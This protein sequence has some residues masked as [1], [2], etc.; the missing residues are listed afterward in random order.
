[1]KP[2]KL[3]DEEFY[4][5]KRHPIYSSILIKI[6]LFYSDDYENEGVK[7]YAN[8][9][10]QIALY[11]HITKYDG[12]PKE[13]SHLNLIVETEI[14]RI[15]DIYQALSSKRCYKD[16]FWKDS[17]LEIIEK[18]RE[19]FKDSNVL[20][21]F[22]RHRQELDDIMEER[23][24]IPEQFIS[25]WNESIDNGHKKIEAKIKEIFE[26]EED[27]VL[28]KFEEL[29]DI[30]ESHFRE[31]ESL[32]LQYEYPWLEA[33]TNFHEDMLQRLKNVLFYDIKDLNKE[34]LKKFII[35]WFKRA[36]H[37]HSKTLD[38]QFSHWLLN[39]KD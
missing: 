18:L 19:T 31:E 15:A 3:T 11:H 12:Y 20:E 16:S 10:I 4:I 22:Y 32:M 30:T 36:Y 28:S 17:V 24:S 14:V 8:K 38:T 5:I 13:C 29:I 27:T 26:S 6:L 1:M 2:W 21:A 35:I 37:F 34:F 9:L 33:H 7:E 23:K 39:K 25:V